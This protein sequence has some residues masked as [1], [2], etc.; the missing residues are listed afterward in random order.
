MWR[1]IFLLYA[2]GPRWALFQ[3]RYILYI[4]IIFF[5]FLFPFPFT[6][7]KDKKTLTVKMSYKF[8]GRGESYRIVTVVISWACVKE[9]MHDDISSSY[10]SPSSGFFLHW[11]QVVEFK[12]KFGSLTLC[13]GCLQKEIFMMQHW[14]ESKFCI[15]KIAYHPLSDGIRVPNLP[16][17]LRRITGF[18]KQKEVGV[19]SLF[20]HRTWI[21]LWNLHLLKVSD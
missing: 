17:L 2:T 5:P 15:E 14:S 9:A 8:P 16:N 4:Y 13:L 6:F 18:A 10:C 1:K 20:L 3:A 19:M 21:W 12:V 7:S 11:L